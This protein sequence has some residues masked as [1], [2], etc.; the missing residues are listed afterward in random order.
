MYSPEYFF[1]YYAANNYLDCRVYV[2]LAYKNE[3][4]F[5]YSCDWFEWQPYFERN[6]DE[7]WDLAAARSVN[8]LMHCI[9]VAEKGAESTDTQIPIQM[10]YLDNDCYDWREMYEVWQSRR[11]P[12]LKLDEQRPAT[13]APYYSSHYRYLGSD[14]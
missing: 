3:T 1:S 11:Q 2:T 4:R 14:R 9:V 8:G 13:H 10:Q 6:A 12:V 7:Y 5:H